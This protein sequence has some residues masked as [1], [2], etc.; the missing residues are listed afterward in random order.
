MTEMKKIFILGLDGLE[1]DF[2]EKWN[3]VHLKQREYGKIIVPIAEK[4]GVP[5]TPEVWASFLTGKHIKVSFEDR[6]V[7]LPVLKILKILRKYVN[8]SL[9]LDKKN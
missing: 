6:N 2:V 7:V 1:Y 4:L 3:L 5:N 9:G 8:V